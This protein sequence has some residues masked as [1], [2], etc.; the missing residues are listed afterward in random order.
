[1]GPHM[2]HGP[3]ADM[4]SVPWYFGLGSPTGLLVLPSCSRSWKLEHSFPLVAALGQHHLSTGC[5][6]W[7]G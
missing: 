4:P 5:W 2:E 1:M 6:D 3:P 7:M